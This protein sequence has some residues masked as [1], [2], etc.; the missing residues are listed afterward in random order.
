MWNGFSQCCKLLLSRKAEVDWCRTP[1][2]L[3]MFGFSAARSL[4]DF[5]PRLGSSL[6]H[7]SYLL[8]WLLHPLLHLLHHSYHHQNFSSKA[9]C[10]AGFHAVSKAAARMLLH[11]WS[12]YIW[13]FFTN[14]TQRDVTVG[15]MSKCKIGHENVDQ[16]L[17]YF[18]LKTSGFFNRSQR[19]PLECWMRL[20]FWDVM[21]EPHRG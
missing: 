14:I 4:L 11:F 3:Q 9:E 6:E 10:H 17:M 13:M 12:Y 7:S 20:L 1:S 2:R 8:L 16:C 15:Q 19:F 5:D 18:Y 21:I